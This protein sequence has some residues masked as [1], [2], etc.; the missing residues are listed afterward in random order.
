MTEQ[1]SGIQAN[2]VIHRVENNDQSPEDW[3][4]DGDG[5][6]YSI[7]VAGTPCFTSRLS[8]LKVASV[9]AQF[10]E[11]KRQLVTEIGFGGML[12][13]KSWQKINL[14]YSAYLM[15]RVDLGSSSINLESQG[16]LELGHKDFI[17]VFGIPCSNLN[18]QGE[19]VEPSEACIEY[20]R[21]AAS[22]SDKGT[23]SLKAA[24]TVLHRDITEKSTATD[25]DC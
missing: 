2:M 6:G 11:F 12:E 16:V 25:R 19:G 5:S 1:F 23:H 9:I 17:Y 10:T 24:E 7:G 4:S 14:K 22:F 3:N 8:L 20:T 21:V 13:I 18:I 15:D